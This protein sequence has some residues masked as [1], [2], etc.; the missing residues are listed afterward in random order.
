VLYHPLRRTDDDPL[1]F[2]DALAAEARDGVA[3]CRIGRREAFLVTAPA[4]VEEVLVRRASSFEKGRGYLRAAR[5]VGG[6]L[7]TASGETHA[8]R[9]RLLQPV[10]HRT[11]LAAWAGTMT[12]HAASVRDRWRAGMAV[13]VAAEMQALSLDIAG[14]TLFGADLSAHAADVRHAVASAVSPFDGLLAV[15]APPRH[16]RGARDTLGRIVETILEARRDSGGRDDL[17]DLVMGQAGGDPARVRD[18]AA[19]F[20]LAAHDTIALALTWTWVLL[21][22]HPGSAVQ[23]Q[24]EL[25][26]VLDGRL[27]AAA[28]LDALP[29]TRAVFAEALRLR[30]PAWVIVR[31][32]VGPDRLG[33]MP[34]PAGSLVIVSPWVLHRDPR[35]FPDPERFAPD[36]WRDADARPPKFAYLPFGAGGR[37]C[38]GE[39]F[40]W[41]EGMLVL[42]TIAQRWRLEG[43]V[44][45]VRP[46]PR[47][48]LRPAGPVRLLP[49]PAP[50]YAGRP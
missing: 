4:L 23:L 50:A 47:M 35:T 44:G 29:V 5:L 15:V 26:A 10:F 41:M 34:L 39:Q 18:E 40:A 14:A 7:L 48:T 31:E 16:L 27:P 2:L 19:T 22:A 1:A 42:A 28:D 25:D 37:S 13:D 46:A 38:I 3:P 21:A 30:P 8:A 20:L 9:R 17:L 49:V 45:T 32:A 36:R 24:E 43:P 6:G 33:S 12:A 11:R